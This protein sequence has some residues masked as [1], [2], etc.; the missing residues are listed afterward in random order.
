MR[1][2]PSKLSSDPRSHRTSAPAART[3]APTP[4][5]APRLPTSA[6]EIER[7][8]RIA[9]NRSRR[10]GARSS[11]AIVRNPGGAP[12][13][14]VGSEL[15]AAARQI[16]AGSRR[17]LAIRDRILRAGVEHAADLHSER[18]GRDLR[19]LLREAADPDDPFRAEEG[20]HLVERLVAELE[21]GIALLGADLLWRD[22]PPGLL[23]EG[24]RAVI[25]DAERREE[26]VGLAERVFRPAPE[27]TA[28]HLAPRAIEPEH[29]PLRMLA[30]RLLHL[31][32][33]AEPLA[34]EAYLTE[35]HSGLH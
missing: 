2:S 12:S 19:A 26:P 22:V 32:A 25:E 4:S 5:A 34:N 13:R 9:A 28:A 11:W 30:G 20:D 17:P 33:D 3:R 1:S 18:S 27:A 21:Q 14:N 15:D 24:K 29:R 31:P 10:G 8:S 16:R 23:H 7:G 35:R 6:R